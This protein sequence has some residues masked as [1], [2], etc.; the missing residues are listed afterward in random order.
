[1]YLDSAYIA[2]YYLNEP[3][4][5]QVRSTITGTSP[6]VSSIWAL[7]EV[8]WAFHRNLREGSLNASQFQA[9]LGAF[10]HH[11][12]SGIWTFVPVTERLLRKMTVFMK[13]LPAA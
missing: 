13:T 2:K 3:D 9:L 1:M 11:A 7:G 4:S 10:L 6:P 5:P 8:A 12:D